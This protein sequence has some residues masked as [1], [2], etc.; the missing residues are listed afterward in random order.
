MIKASAGFPALASGKFE[1]SRP[2]FS[3]TPVT[4]QRPVVQKKPLE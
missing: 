1:F 3:K 2:E 4:A